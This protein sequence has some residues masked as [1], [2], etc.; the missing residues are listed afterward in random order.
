MGKETSRVET[1]SDSVFVSPS[2]CPFSV[3]RFVFR[4]G[5][6]GHFLIMTTKNKETDYDKKEVID[7][8]INQ[9]INENGRNE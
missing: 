2:F 8:V 9:C 3:Y 6:S 4:Y 5:Y 7:P 1:F